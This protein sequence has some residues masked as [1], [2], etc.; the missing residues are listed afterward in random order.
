MPQTNVQQN[1]NDK[2]TISD[3]IKNISKL[4]YFQ[5]FKYNFNSSI[6]TCLTRRFQKKDSRMQLSCFHPSTFPF[7]NSK[8]T[9]LLFFK[10]SHFYLKKILAILKPKKSF[11]CLFKIFSRSLFC[12]LF[13]KIT[14]KNNC[15]RQFYVLIQ[16][17][18]YIYPPIHVTRILTRQT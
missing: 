14:T 6:L 12:Y 7:F 8:K 4:T 3:S 11:Y 18:N 2:Q 15:S 13:F 5:F 10:S 17:H 9:T 16:L 1:K